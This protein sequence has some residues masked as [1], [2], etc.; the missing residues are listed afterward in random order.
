VAVDSR[1]KVR[2]LRLSGEDR[3]ASHSEDDCQSTGMQAEEF[4]TIS[5]PWSQVSVS[6][7]SR[8]GPVINF[9]FGMSFLVDSCLPQARSVNK[10]SVFLVSVLFL[11]VVRKKQR[12]ISPLF[13][14]TIFYCQS[15]PV[16]I[17]LPSPSYSLSRLPRFDSTDGRLLHYP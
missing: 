15:T 8:V 1:G 4:L 12:P 9:I 10:R 2:R 16:R 6:P 5:N 7:E 17:F 13:T 11:T 14:D 3:Q